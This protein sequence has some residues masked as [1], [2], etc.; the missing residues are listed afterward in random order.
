MDT[1]VEQIVRKKKT[2]VD[3]LIIFGISVAAL[4]VSFLIWRFVYLLFA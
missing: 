3:W 4:I 2:A 1:F